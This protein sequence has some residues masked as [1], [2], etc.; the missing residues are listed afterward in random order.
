MNPY[1]KYGFYVYEINVT[2][3]PSVSVGHSLA[4]PGTSDTVN[5]SAT[6]NYFDDFIDNTTIFVDG[7]QETVCYDKTLLCSITRTF[8]PGAHTYYAV[9][10]DNWDNSARDPAS[11]TKGFTIASPSAGGGTGGSSGISGGGAAA[12][13]RTITVTE[14]TAI[15]TPQTIGST[16]QTFNVPSDFIIS[17]VTMQSSSSASGVSV[18]IKK[19]NSANIPQPPGTLY[20]YVRIDATNTRNVNYI[21]VTFDVERQWLDSNGFAPGE[22]RMLRYVY[23]W[24]EMPTFPISEN[25][26]HHRFRSVLPGFSVFAVVG[27]RI[28]GTLPETTSGTGRDSEE[29]LA[30]LVSSKSD[31]FTLPVQ[32]FIISGVFFA[33]AALL[34]VYYHHKRLRMAAASYEP[35]YAGQRQ[36]P[37]DTKM[38]A[39]FGGTDA[40]EDMKRHIERIRE[41][42][43]KM[44]NGKEEK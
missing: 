16:A 6:L 21:E 39:Y 23:D 11:G 38:P 27:N 35:R 2:D 26:T 8:S 34:Y 19:I 36:Q 17:S 32:F 43:K 9:T 20:N 14:D 44:K 37:S 12:P 22:V 42:L 40:G 5:I 29:P 25:A 13:Q 1:D 4:S 18:A 30:P 7:V 33:V 10:Y 28:D 31:Y 3:P 41:E 24:E 15:I